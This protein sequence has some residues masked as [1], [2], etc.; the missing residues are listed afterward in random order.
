MRKFKK[1]SGVLMLAFACLA[2]PNAN[3][4]KINIPAPSPLATVA[5]SFGL[6]EIKIVYSRP[7]ARGRGIFGK[8]VPFD[9]VWRTGANSTT[10]ITFTDNVTIE[11]QKVKAGTYGIYTIPHQDSWEVMLYSDL[12]L[13]GNVAYYKKENELFRFK[14]KAMKLPVKIETFTIGIG[15]ITATSSNLELM[16]ENTY[17]SL[18]ITT[19]ID[20]K[21]MKSIDASMK[22]DNPSYFQAAKYYYKH[23]KDLN[24]ALV[25][26]KKA[27]KKN[28]E[29]FYMIY[30]KAQI[31]YKLGDKEAGLKSATETI[32]L[33][34]KVKYDHYVMLGKELIEANK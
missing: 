17:V 27:V 21:I 34:K 29:A 4:Q 22:S 7:S 19:K 8:L 33:A 32:K 12:E 24:K 23:G 15:N 1:I 9:K 20:D 11:G 26:I 16:W 13:G 2:T 10:Q 5:Q 30:V 25:W 3:A 6:G 18:K 14:V 28:P 31:E